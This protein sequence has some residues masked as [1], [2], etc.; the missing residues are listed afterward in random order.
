MSPRTL[1]ALW[2]ALAAFLLYTITGG[3]RI[4][5]SDE[6]TMLELSRSM[7]HGHLDVPEGATLKGPD[8]RFFTK[9]APGQA[10]LA[11]PLVAIAES[12]TR[13]AGLGPEKQVLALR[14]FVSFFNAA[15]VAVL[16]AV[17]YGLARELG[18]GAGAAIF[19]SAMLGFTTPLWVYAKSFMAEPLQGLGL[20]F[21]LWGALR[22]AASRRWPVRA[23][24]G[25]LLATLVKP[26]MGP[27]ALLCLWPLWKSAGRRG[28]VISGVLVAASLLFEGLYNWG[29][30]HNLFE[31]GYGAQA[32]PA[33][34]TTPLL[35]GLYGL[36]FSS[37]KGLLW[38]APAVWL[39][40]AGWSSMVKSGERGR[41]VAV[42]SIAVVALA[43]L[44]YSTFEHWAGD[45]SFGPRYLVPMLPLLFLAVGFAWERRGR[46]FRSLATVLA[47]LGLLVQIGGVAIHFGAEMREVGDYPYDRPLNDRRFMSESHFDPHFSPIAIHWQMLLRNASE[48]LHGHAPRLEAA[49]TPDARVGVSSADQERLLHGI[50]FWWLYMS[51]AG[52]YAWPIGITLALL[53]AILAWATIR[54]RR[55]ALHEARAG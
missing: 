6:V 3:G 55:A 50:D 21:T 26:S 44:L 15:V 13:A 7:L 4:V 5:G 52:F 14:F 35:V 8:G 17:F 18:I 45:G 12:A 27:L 49:G 19:A 33:A 28:I 29:R 39:A 41:S 25:F 10:L 48:H 31:T 9:N 37:G 43:L 2:I 51:Y 23:S 1:T 46:A 11:L 16:L 40:P 32:T 20:L 53:F 36:V 30:F 47:T 42:T 38:F 54:L 22:G 24:I 34:Y